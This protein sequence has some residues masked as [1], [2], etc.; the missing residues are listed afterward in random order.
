MKNVSSDGN[1]DIK[2]GISEKTGFTLGQLASMICLTCISNFLMMYLTDVKFLDI[3]KISAIFAVS[4]FFDVVSDLV[5]GGIIDRTRSKQGKARIWILRMAVPCVLCLILLFNIP[6]GLSNSIMYV[7]L[8]VFL[9]LLRTIFL[10]FENISG[11]SM[12]ALMTSDEKEHDNLAVLKSIALAGGIVVVS[13]LFSAL[14]PVFSDDPS[15]PNTQHGYTLI[16]LM[17]GAVILLCY[18]ISYFTMKERVTEDEKAGKPRRK[19][20]EILS[21]IKIMANNKYW[22]ILLFFSLANMI[23][24]IITASGITYFANY[25]LGD[26]K[27]VGLMSM[28]GT[29][30]GVVASMVFVPILSRSAGKKTILIIGCA[31]FT[32]TGIGITVFAHNTAILYV[33]LALNGAGKGLIMPVT[34]SYMPDCITYTMLKNGRFLPGI[35][36]G[37]I[38]AVEKMGQG[39]GNVIFG[40]IMAAVGFNAAASV[41]PDAVDPALCGMLGIF[42]AILILIF[43]VIFCIFFDIDKKLK[44]LKNDD[45]MDR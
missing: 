14:L 43:G 11:N 36:S 44:Q 17:F 38:S 32:L 41:Q 22:L 42:P 1:T 33:L 16:A 34:L 35:C 8:V 24:T 31:L 45:E 9:I 6:S 23:G 2:L 12:L 7:Y 37:G 5:I 27:A 40:A 19:Y 26:I 39:L 18:V 3:G 10:T 13:M 25:V 20:T 4:A 28:S 30:A 29:V 15:Q 21:D